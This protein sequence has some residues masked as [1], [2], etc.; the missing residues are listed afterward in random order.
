MT[1]I[2]LNDGTTIIADTG[3]NEMT[4]HCQRAREKDLIL[5]VFDTFTKKRFSFF[6]ESISHL[7]E[8]EGEQ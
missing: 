4:A 6:A 7:C 5:S 1:E 3:F 2:I 8:I